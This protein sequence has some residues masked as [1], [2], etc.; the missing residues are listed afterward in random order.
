MV[1][2]EVL[3]D[4]PGNDQVRVKMVAAGI[5]ASDGHFVWGEQKLAD[6]YGHKLPV[7][8][9]HEGSGIVESVGPNVTKVKPGDHV[10][11]S[12]MAE[13]QACP[14]CVSPHTNLCIRDNV[15]TL[16]TTP[17]KTLAN[18]TPL[19][20]LAGEGVFS[21]F[22]LLK[23]SQVVK[24]NNQVSKEILPLIQCEIR[25]MRRQI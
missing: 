15:K 4:A 25:L 12:F 11:L 13:C 17:N 16:A 8:L 22:V 6:F 5:C 21:E 3:V 19:Y 20:A 2:E 18:G 7:V 1:I 10:L 9:G 14:T 23:A 24:V